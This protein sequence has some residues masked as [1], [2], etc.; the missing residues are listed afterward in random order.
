M[1]A[2]QVSSR[3]EF[4][5]EKKA[6]KNVEQEEPRKIRIRLIPI[7]L[8]VIL[9]ALAMSISLVL[10][11]MV[12]YG[13]LGDGKPLDALKPSTWQHIVDLVEKE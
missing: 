13:V 3:E 10:G 5:K 6:K 12:G 9:V 1:G 4:K 11:T 2:E 7:W 8:R